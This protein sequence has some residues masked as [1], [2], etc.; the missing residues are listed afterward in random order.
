MINIRGDGMQQFA[1]VNLARRTGDRFRD[2]DEELRQRVLS[3][4]DGQAAGEHARM[5]V[6]D[7]GQLDSE[8]Q[9]RVFGEA[10]PKGLR[11]R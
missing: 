9:G 6:R 10:L 2:I 5:L 1:I 3:C 7:G 11:L 8:E 4:L